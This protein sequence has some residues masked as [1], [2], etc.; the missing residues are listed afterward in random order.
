MNV[1]SAFKFIER[2]GNTLELYREKYLFHSFRE[3]EVPLRYLRG[4]QNKDGGFPYNLEPGKP[5]SVNETD[6]ILSLI[7]EL[8]LGK[9]DTGHKVID[10]LFQI[11]RPDGGWDENPRSAD[12]NLPDGTPQTA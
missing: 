10:Y 6:G 2:F 12:S 11:Q 8:D 1:E 7:R 9:S 5:S 4:F 3:D